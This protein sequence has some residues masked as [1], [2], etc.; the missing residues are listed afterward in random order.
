MYRIE[1]WRGAAHGT[2]KARHTLERAFALRK[3]LERRYIGTHTLFYIV[4]VPIKVK[5][6]VH[7]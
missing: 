2:G 5:E 1:W 7:A 4:A 3:K 6:A